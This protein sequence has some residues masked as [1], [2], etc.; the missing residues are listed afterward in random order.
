M[1]AAIPFPPEIRERILCGTC[2][3]QEGWKFQDSYKTS[4]FKPR[5]IHSLKCFCIPS[6]TSTAFFL[7]KIIRGTT[8]HAKAVTTSGV[9]LHHSHPTAPSAEASCIPQLH[10]K[11]SGGALCL[12][13]APCLGSSEVGEGGSAI[14]AQKGAGASASILSMRSTCETG[15]VPRTH[16][17]F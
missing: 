14:Q 17:F 11:S 8:C 6:C 15:D 10:R 4:L 13:W 9:K 1:K 2:L 7:Q 5:G 3:H 12:I 16:Y